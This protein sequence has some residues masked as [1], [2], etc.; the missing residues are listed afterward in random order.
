MLLEN[1]HDIVLKR[2]RTTDYHRGEKKK[3]ASKNVFITSPVNKQ[4][5]GYVRS[6][7]LFNNSE[8][9]VNNNNNGSHFETS[10]QSSYYDDDDDDDN[11]NNNDYNNNTSKSN[12]V[13]YSNGSSNSNDIQLESRQEKSTTNSNSSLQNLSLSLS[14]H[15][16]MIKLVHTMFG[17]EFQ[18]Y[19][20]GS[21]IILILFV[22]VL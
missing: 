14:L 21:V 6:Y 2:I 8:R 11:N 15:E 13:K 4:S 5:G 9:N 19:D 10:Y 18:F 17:D 3:A 12:N 7:T 1:E 20:S 22:F 16:N